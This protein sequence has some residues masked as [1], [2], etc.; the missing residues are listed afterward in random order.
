MIHDI[1][2]RVVQVERSLLEAISEANSIIAMTSPAHPSFSKVTEG[3]ITGGS[4][5]LTAG[6]INEIDKKKTWQIY[7]TLLE[8][9][10]QMTSQYQRSDTK[11]ALLHYHD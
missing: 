5:Y 8:E 1:H 4:R 7:T 9:V 6:A 2:D 11:S 3:N 10:R